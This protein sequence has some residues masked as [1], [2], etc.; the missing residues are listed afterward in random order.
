MSVSEA[1]NLSGRRHPPVAVLIMALLIG[2]LGLL[3]VMQ[4]PQ[5]ETY[6]TLHVIQLVVSGAG[7]GVALFGFMVWILRPKW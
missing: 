6:R 2:L 7:F 5:F 4:S 3:R 1:S